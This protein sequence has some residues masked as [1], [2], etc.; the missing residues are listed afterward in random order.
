MIASP[1]DA[2]T[3][4]YVTKQVANYIT[5]TDYERVIL[6]LDPNVWKGKITAACRWACKKK[7]I[8]FIVLQE[9]DP[10]ITNTIEHLV[11]AIQEAV[12]AP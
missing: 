11:S 9:R 4:M 8:P 7:Q 6:L 1:F 2:E 3:V 5:K 12:M 10:W